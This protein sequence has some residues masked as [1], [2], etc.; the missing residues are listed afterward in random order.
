MCGIVGY[1][2][3]DGQ[4]PASPEILEQMVQKIRYRGPDDKGIWTHG[5]VGF[6]HCRLSILDLS[7]NAHQPF[8]TA[9]GQGVLSYNGEVYNFRELRKDLERE[10]VQFKSTS[11]TEVVLYSLHQWGPERAVKLFNGMFAF[12]Y[13]DLR[14]RTMWLGRD[15]MGIK[16]LYCANIGRTIVFGSE[17]KALFAHPSVP[18]K[19]DMHALTTQLIY[20]R[21]DG[22]WTPFEKVESVLPGTLLKI[23]STSNETITYFDILRD[24]NVDRIIKNNDVDFDSFLSEFNELFASSVKMHLISDAPLATLASGGLDSSHMTAVAK[25]F[26]RDI[27]AY[28]ADVE[29]VQIKEAI[30]AKQVCDHVGIELRPVKI[31]TEKYLRTWPA[32]VYQN[33]QP[34]YFAQNV[35]F[36]AL[37]EAARKDGF[38]VLLCGEGSDELFGGYAWHVDA[39]RMWRARRL[40]SNFIPNVAPLRFVSRF[41]NKLA[42]LNFEELSIK[43]FEHLSKAPSILM[44]DAL[45]YFTLDGG[46]RATREEALFRKLAKIEPIEERAFLARAF[47]DCYSHLRTSMGCND[48]MGMLQSVEVRVP[49]LENKLIDF[50]LHLPCSAKYK[51]GITKYLVKK[52]AEKTIPYDIIHSRK[53]GFGISNHVWRNTKEFLKDGVLPEL[54]KWTPSDMERIGKVAFSDHLMPFHLLSTELWARIYFRNESPEALGEELYAIGGK[55]GKNS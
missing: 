34:N 9:D 49:F 10:G 38:K 22:A 4:Q 24:V 41:L 5:P 37:A 45:A 40:H 28:V 35:A 47:E 29:G 3:R 14:T 20:Q 30:K 12:S 13:Y 15:R 2:N 31:D 48:K 25:Q 11:D 17:I 52:A 27:V 46:I 54:F 44:N 39:Y 18:C 6:G 36:T 26:K 53:I 8:L 33:D 21:L 55:N 16:P 23:T 19:P 1:W 32:V 43:P 50:G 51:K 42:P 7:Q